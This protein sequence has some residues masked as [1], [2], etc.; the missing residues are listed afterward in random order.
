MVASSC[1][2][3]S[4]CTWGL[5][6]SHLI[7]NTSINLHILLYYMGTHLKSRFLITLS[8]SL[9]YAMKTANCRGNFG[10]T[11]KMGGAWP[12]AP[13]QYLRAVESILT[14]TT[15]TSSLSAS[16]DDPL[17]SLASSSTDF[18]NRQLLANRSPTPRWSKAFGAARSKA[19]HRRW[20]QLE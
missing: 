8:V 14:T 13:R 3:L 5:Y 11:G 7:I 10:L 4:E 17:A 16:T 12:D 15:L 2:A 1:W 9:D 20:R 6:M 19:D 18:S